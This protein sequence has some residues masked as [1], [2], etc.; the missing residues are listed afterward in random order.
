MIS[1]YGLRGFGR[2]VSGGAV[3]VGISRGFCGCGMTLTV[4]N[5][6]LVEMARRSS[7]NCS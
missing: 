6:G 3:D 2:G 1:M 7:S 4:G 5:M